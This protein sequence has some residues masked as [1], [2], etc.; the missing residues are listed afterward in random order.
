MTRLLPG[1]TKQ[2]EKV[3]KMSAT[4]ERNLL[5]LRVDKATLNKEY[6]DVE[7]QIDEK[8]DE[9]ISKAREDGKKIK[10]SLAQTRAKQLEEIENS[11]KAHKMQ[12]DS[13]R[14]I[15]GLAEST[16]MSVH[17]ASQLQ[18]IQSDIRESLEAQ[19]QHKSDI[20]QCNSQIAIEFKPLAT[21]T[22]NIIGSLKRKRSYDSEERH[23]ALAFDKDSTMGAL[24]EPTPKQSMFINRSLKDLSRL[25]TKLKRKIELG[26]Y[27]SRLIKIHGDLW[28]I[29][30]TTISK[31]HIYSIDGVKKKTLPFQGIEYCLRVAQVD[32][33]LILAA[34]SGLFITDMD[35]ANCRRIIDDTIQDV[36]VFDSKVYILNNRS[37]KLHIL[38]QNDNTD[39]YTQDSEFSILDYD[40]NC[41]NTLQV[42]SHF[43]YIA[44]IDMYQIL[45]YRHD[46]TL[47]AAYGSYGSN[48]SDLN[49]P[50]LCG[51]DADGTLLIADTVNNR[52]K[53]LTCDGEWRCLQVQGLNWPEFA[54]INENSLLIKD[55]EGLKEYYFQ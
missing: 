7:K 9:I 20:P 6:A 39:S 25:Q 36:S 32:Q 46:G 35:G 27:S 17:D 50:R 26:Y 47:V 37:R 29:E 51:A 3:Q 2:Q 43:I 52:L 42:T 54:L 23:E 34:E 11:E 30:C 44:T 13:Q 31:I 15:A 24:A 18:V 21:Q 33:G 40:E 41:D 45:Q 22:G 55:K 48:V 19:A 12:L 14:N 5:K 4:T 38:K 49:S 16:I 10:D 1:V 28:S 8:V 53:T